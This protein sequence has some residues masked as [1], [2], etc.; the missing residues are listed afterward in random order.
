MDAKLLRI[1]NNREEKYPHALEQQYPRIL[2]K[3]LSLWDTPSIEAYFADLLVDDR[4][5]RAGFPKDVASD[6]FYLSTLIPQEPEADKSDPWKNAPKAIEQ[7]VSRQNIQFSP[8]GFIKASEEGESDVV[9]L[10]LSAGVNVDTC[11]DRHWTPLM[12]AAFNGKEEVVTLLLKN[13]ANI[14][15]KDH[16]GY[17][18]LHWA[19][20]NGHA[21]VVKLLLSNRADVNARSNHGWTPLLQAATR[22]HLSA[23]FM[24]IEK[25]ADVN[26]A[27]NE[28]WTP[29]HKAAANGHLPEVML[30]LGKGADAGIEYADGKTAL[31]F[32]I[33]NKHDQIAAKLS[34]IT[35][36]LHKQG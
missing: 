3:I 34:A 15:Y 19:A 35:Q 12:F 9:T 7:E 22:G 24:L 1:L 23:S 21:G 27:S 10:F 13:R 17:S 14:N 36:D 33:K 29:L 2:N 28:G 18:P 11:D 16:A 4:G 5:N 32:A 31:D 30:L 8:Q 6:I 26:A 20:F 25:G